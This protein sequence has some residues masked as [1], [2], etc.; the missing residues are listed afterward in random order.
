M[1]NKEKINELRENLKKIN[2][3]IKKTM[4]FDKVPPVFESIEKE[5]ICLQKELNTIESQ[6]K[7]LSTI[8]F[9]NE[10]KINAYEK[11]EASGNLWGQNWFDYADKWKEVK[12]IKENN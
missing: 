6:M 5:S 7:D 8:K 3:K 4:E 12:Q 10:K 9:N 2:E 11:W 1:E